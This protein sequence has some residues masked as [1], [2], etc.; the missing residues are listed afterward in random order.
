M[1]IITITTGNNELTYTGG[2]V[3]S[4]ASDADAKPGVLYFTGTPF[5]MGDNLKLNAFWGADLTVPVGMT[6]SGLAGVGPGSRLTVD[7]IYAPGNS[8]GTALSYGSMVLNPGSQLNIEIDGVGTVNGAGNYDRIVLLE[9]T[10]TFAAG[11]SL[12]PVLRGIGSGSNTFTPALG[13]GF[14]IVTA[15]GGVSGS[16]AELTQPAD[17]LAAGTRLD[18]V[19]GAT[20]L[21]LYATPASYSNI[22]AAGV[23][24]NNN[25]QQVGVILEDIRPDAGIRESNATRKY[26]FDS[27]APQTTSSLAVALDQLSG[28]GY[29][30]LIGMN[31][32][33]S[34]F[35]A[36]QIGSTVALQRRSEP[37]LPGSGQNHE[38]MPSAPPEE[39]WGS[40][41]GRIANWSGDGVGHDTSDVLSG[42]MGGVQK[43]FTGQSLAGIALAYAYSNPSIA[44]NLGNGPMQN[45]QLMGYVS[46]AMDTG[47]YVQGL[48][49]GG[50]GSI[51]ASR[52][53]T[54]M[55]TS[56]NTVIN[57]A[58]I[59]GSVLAGWAV[60]SAEKIRYEAGVG[61]NY[62]GMYQSGFTDSGSQSGY[63]LSTQ[64]GNAQSLVPNISATASIP[65]RAR[66]IDWIGYGQANVGYETADNRITM[67][68]N[69]LGTP[70][71]VESGSV[72][73]TH[74]NLGVGVA[75]SL[76]KETKVALDVAYQS[77]QNWNA[78]AAYLSLNVGF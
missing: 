54:M 42:A 8:P 70:I 3:E 18:T 41:L 25:R 28:V 9:A 68:S 55:N 57:T 26:L 1:K 22:A 21:D 74:L 4:S 29:G 76:G 60:E 67:Q 48:L 12:V 34:K 35:L 5:T 16:F 50:G 24:A 6:L 32:E 27:L 37:K 65:F 14:R 33:N 78:V 49:G 61:V 47:F 38:Q 36:N 73:R 10:S 77:A 23:A 19:Y 44:D 51:N 75:G 11:G 63:A 59:A 2:V 13:Q 69:F 43:R 62:Q 30:Q 53:I 72:G 20:Y 58:N 45:L 71:S 40:A 64:A 31:F 17:G 15:P 56:Y 7:G 39:M 46:H 52:N 66:Q